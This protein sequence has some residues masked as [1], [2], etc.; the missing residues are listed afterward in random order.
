[1]SR[2]VSVKNPEDEHVIFALNEK[3][4]Q[5]AV[6]LREVPFPTAYEE[7]TVSYTNPYSTNIVPSSFHWRAVAGDRHVQLRKSGTPWT[8]TDVY[9]LVDKGEVL[10][11]ISLIW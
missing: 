7:V 10:V 8:A 2:P 6:H 9:F 11:D 5:D 3:G 1:M 4:L